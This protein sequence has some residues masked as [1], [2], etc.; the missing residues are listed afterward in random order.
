MAA[1]RHREPA[2]ES[3]APAEEFAAA[4]P[5]RALFAPAYRRFTLAAVAAGGLSAVA[6]A[7]APLAQRMLIDCVNRHDADG[8]LRGTIYLAAAFALLFLGSTANRLLRF[9]LVVEVRCRV[10]SAIFRRLLGMPESFLRSRG[11]GYFFNRLQSDSGE[12]VGFCGGGALAQFV[13]LQKFLFAFGALAALN[14]RCAAL[15]VPFLCF[16]VLVYRICRRRQYRL[17]HRMQEYNA[18]EGYRMQ[19]FLSGHTTLKTHTGAAEEASREV[20]RGFD[21]WRAIASLRLLLENRFQLLVRLPELCFCAGIALYGIRRSL[22]GV[23]SLGEVW[24]LLLLTH[25]LFGPLRSLSAARFQMQTTQA[26]W[27]RLRSLYHAEPERDPGDG[28]AKL[29]P[30]RALLGDIEFSHVDFSYPGGAPLLRDL[31]FTVRGG[32]LLFLTG[33]NGSGKS[34][35]LLLLMR[36]YQP[37][38]GS[39]SVGGT[40]ID[41]FA[42][43]P[44]R[45]R[46]GFLNQT[47]EFF[48]GTIRDNLLLGGK[49]DDGEIMELLRRISSEEI[50]LRRPGGLDAPVEER[51]G[52]LSGG[53]KMRLALARELLRDTDILL[54]D[55]AAAGL[56]F[57]AR[58]NFYALL[59]RL[60]GSRTVIA[61]LHG[62][63]PPDL[64]EIP[65]LHLERAAAESS[66]LR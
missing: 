3:A 54:L 43:A 50:V 20:T 62:E 57:E 34:T 44:Y 36:L 63:V 12:V 55:E 29:L 32:E 39:I 13:D 38:A 6:L 42:A 9:R 19:E 24:A 2:P 49:H 11:S 41:N 59:P 51:G 5:L 45:A 15:T 28:E 47:P 14:W 10:K 61:V 31:S 17:G 37:A 48:P 40:P 27:E 52:N 53:E 18:A 8:A 1:A 4:T 7:C 60:R 26:A 56:D 21:R 30:P 33:S 22:D 58:K 25:Q 64:A 65:M 66:V 35:I 46:L 23:W 16:H